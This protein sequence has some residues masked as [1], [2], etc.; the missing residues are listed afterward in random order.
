MMAITHA[1]IAT[2]GASLLL[3]TAQPLPLAL[4]VL[5]SQ[6]PDIDTRTSIIGQVF[7][8]INSWIEDRFPHRSHS[9]AGGDGCD[10]SGIPKHR[11]SVGQYQDDGGGT[12]G[13]CVGLFCR[14]LY[15]LGCSAVLA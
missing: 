9:F 6:L 2:A 3:G 11:R 4:A 1:E 15:A 12:P 7:Y 8:P 5:G 14:L 10:C 13:S